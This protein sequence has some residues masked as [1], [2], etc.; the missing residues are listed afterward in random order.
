MLNGSFDLPTVLLVELTE[1]FN[2][3]VKIIIR[4]TAVSWKRYFKTL[5]EVA[6]DMGKT[7]FYSAQY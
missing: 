3:S 4:I 5:T 6:E 2:D 1:C 7:A